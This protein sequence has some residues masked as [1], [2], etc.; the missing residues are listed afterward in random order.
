[1]CMVKQR[2]T[3]EKWINLVETH[4]SNLT[5]CCLIKH[6]P[7]GIIPGFIQVARPKFAITK[8]VITP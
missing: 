5:G 2:D 6:S 1:M 8:N 3:F 7:F 4:I